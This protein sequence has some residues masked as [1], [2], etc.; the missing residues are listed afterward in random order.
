MKPLRDPRSARVKAVF[1][2]FYGLKHL[3]SFV[4]CLKIRENFALTLFEL[5]YEYSY[6]YLIGGG[7]NFDP[8]YF[9]Q[10]CSDW[11]EIFQKVVKRKFFEKQ[12]KNYWP[13]V[14]FQAYKT[15]WLKIVK[16]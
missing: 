3:N 2:F 10:K 15:F 16:N 5:G 4:K 12:K 8:P 6:P 7:V 14:I 9:P 13:D 1:T 11:A